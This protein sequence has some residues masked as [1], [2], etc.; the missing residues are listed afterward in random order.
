[1]RLA[2]DEQ[3]QGK[4]GWR[5]RFEDVGF[6]LWCL[7]LPDI[8]KRQR[9]RAERSGKHPDGQTREILLHGC[10]AG[11]F[12]RFLLRR[13]WR[14]RAA[15]PSIS[16]RRSGRRHW[17]RELNQI[18]AVES[19]RRRSALL[20][21]NLVLPHILIGQF[22]RDLKFDGD[23]IVATNLARP[24]G[25]DEVLHPREAFLPSQRLPGLGQ[26]RR[27]VPDWRLRRGSRHRPE[28][29]GRK[30]PNYEKV[31]KTAHTCAPPRTGVSTSSVG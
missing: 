3:A 24:T 16:A 9:I 4:V 1:M 2:I 5:L 21:W 29:T 19:S 26:N 15:G 22:D 28:R 12:H 25:G 6:A 8:R 20:G 11:G 7:S 31:S 13:I 30:N 10:H 14:R 27:R 23:Q 17:Y 18:I